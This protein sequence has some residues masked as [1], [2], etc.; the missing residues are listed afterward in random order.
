MGRAGRR[1]H[2]EPGEGSRVRFHQRPTR[3]AS[4]R[5]ARSIAGLE[6][7]PWAAALVA[8]HALTVDDRL[9]PDGEWTPFFEAMEAA[10]AALLRAAGLPLG[11]LLGI[12]SSSVSPI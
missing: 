1:P 4:G 6:G 7:D 3:P 11:D 8:Q 12:T 2:R 5:L 9:R 10:R